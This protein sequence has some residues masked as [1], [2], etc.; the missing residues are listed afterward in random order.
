MANKVHKGQVALILVLIMTVVSTLAVSLATRSTVDTRI[1]QTESEGVQA[2]LY[3]QSGLEQLVM[4]PLSTTVQDPNYT[5][6]RIDAGINSLDTGLME[7]G[8][9]VEL[10]LAGADFVNLSGLAINWGPDQSSPGDMPAIF[11]SLIENSGK[12]A[13]FAY[14]YDG[15]NNFTQASDI[16]GSLPKSTGSIGLNSNVSKVRITVLGAPALLRVVPIGG[17]V[18]PSQIKS[19]KSTGSVASGNTTVK[20][21][22]QYDESSFDT[23]PSVF[24]Y[25]LFSGGNI[26]Q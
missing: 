1:Q 13:D 12:I 5:A 16:S 26:S 8:S 19:I 25:A 24:D 9:S 17:G 11:V 4:N 18:F 21:G 7:T 22:L 14:N 10:N 20:Y 23:V 6:T 15:A 2:L 3:A